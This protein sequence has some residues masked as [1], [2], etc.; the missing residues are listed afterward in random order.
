M[1]YCECRRGMAPAS[2]AASWCSK[3]RG[4]PPAAVGCPAVN[5]RPQCFLLEKTGGQL[6]FRAKITGWIIKIIRDDTEIMQC[7]HATFKSDHVGCFY[8]QDVQ[9][10]DHLTFA[11]L[12]N[13]NLLVSTV[14]CHRTFSW[15]RKEC[16]DTTPCSSR[17]WVSSRRLTL[18]SL[19]ALPSPVHAR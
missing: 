19:H 5:P 12:A 18:S 14:C 9:C 7:I 13:P 16:C 15:L 1:G 8:I 17:S 10:P 3:R 4:C 2:V 11:S 6:R